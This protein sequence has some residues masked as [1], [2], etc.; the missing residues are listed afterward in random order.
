MNDSPATAPNWLGLTDRVCVVTG[1]AGGIGTEVARQ[2]LGAGARVALLDL[3]GAKAARALDTLG[4]PAGRAIALACDVSREASVQAAA[5]AVH[6]QLGPAQVLVNNAGA[7]YAGALLDLP[8]DR[9]N[10]LLA[11]NLGGYLLCAQQFGR[12]MREQGGGAMVHVGSVSGSVPQPF[13][14][15]YSVS[16]A[17]VAMLSR[18]LAV[19]LAESRIRSNLVSPAMIRTPMSEGIYAQDAVRTLRERIVPAGRIGTPAD[20]AQAVLFLASDQAAYVN[21]Q[22]IL[23]DGGLTQTWLGLI[24]RPGFQKE[25]A[26]APA[27]V[28]A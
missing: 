6:R 23:V 2:L 14:G 3:D 19:E 26:A 25:D 4:A 1:A 5:E 13:S 24:P 12:Q 15:A 11:V 9:W 20:I 21:G 22:E 10:Q 27:A 17:G 28:Q 7:L 16:K 8:I 18:L